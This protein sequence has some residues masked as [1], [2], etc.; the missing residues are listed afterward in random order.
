MLLARKNFK[1]RARVQK[2]HFGNFSIF[3]KWHFW[4]RP[5]MKFDF[6][7]CCLGFYEFLKGIECEMRS[8]PFFGHLKTCTGIV[9]SSMAEKKIIRISY[10]CCWNFC[11]SILVDFGWDSSFSLDFNPPSVFLKK[12]WSSKKWS[13]MRIKDPSFVKPEVWNPVAISIKWF[14]HFLPEP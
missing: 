11:M 12:L 3:P 13:E 6:F 7:C 5:C 14:T 4:T 9:K 10:W 8:S 2:H 1:F